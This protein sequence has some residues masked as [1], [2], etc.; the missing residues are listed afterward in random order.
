MICP[1]DEGLVSKPSN[2][3]KHKMTNVILSKKNNF[4]NFNSAKN[5]MP[6]MDP[7]LYH[8]MVK[9]INKNKFDYANIYQSLE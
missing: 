5:S 6:W 3:D 7:I 1:S 4:N 2:E 9:L 8:D